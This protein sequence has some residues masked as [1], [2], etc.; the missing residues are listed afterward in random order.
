MYRVRGLGLAIR[1]S[2]PVRISDTESQH[3]RKLLLTAGESLF[4][5]K[6][7]PAVLGRQ[8]QDN[9]SVHKLER[10]LN[11]PSAIRGCA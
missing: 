5:S 6:T 11:Q 1:K 8:A 10:Q 9:A 4:L 2:Q 7:R 3:A